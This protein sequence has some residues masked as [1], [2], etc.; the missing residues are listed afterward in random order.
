MGFLYVFF[1]M[2]VE[3]TYFKNT[4]WILDRHELPVEGSHHLPTVNWSILLP[5]G[6]LVLDLSRPKF[7]ETLRISMCVRLY[8]YI[9][10][11]VCAR[12]RARM[13]TSLVIFVLSL[14]HYILW[15]SATMLCYNAVQIVE[16]KMMNRPDQHQWGITRPMRFGPNLHG[17]LLYSSTP[18][19]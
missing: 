1:K 18:V 12:A 19:S 4:C 7:V 17:Y 6:E 3:I 5:H 10:V 16:E 2:H 11:C 14:T 13:K 15:C 8:I 9:Y